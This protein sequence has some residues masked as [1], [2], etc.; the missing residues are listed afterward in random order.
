VQQV[1]SLKA[2]PGHDVN[3]ILIEDKA[4]GSAVVAVLKQ[5]IPG[6]LAIQPEGGQ[7]SRAAAVA[8]LMEAGNVFL[9][10][11]DEHPWIEDTLVEFASFP[12]AKYDD[13]LDAASQALLW[14][15]NRKRAENVR[16]G[17][18]GRV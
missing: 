6:V 1:R 2:R 17:Y 9:P 8:P 13:R 12:A 18:P 4:N 15:R 5:E 11:P 3:A 16:A 7:E 10:I 14:L